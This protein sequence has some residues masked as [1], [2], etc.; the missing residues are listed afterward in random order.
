MDR[1]VIRKRKVETSEDFGHNS[2]AKTPFDV[3]AGP[4]TSSKLPQQSS[5]TD[6]LISRILVI[7]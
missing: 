5:S 7:I 6:S 1:Y 4:S 2:T 3:Q